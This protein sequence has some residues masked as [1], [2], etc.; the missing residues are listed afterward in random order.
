MPGYFLHDLDQAADIVSEIDHPRL[1]ILFD[2]Y[3]VETQHGRCLTRFLSVARRVGHVQIAS[4]PGRNEPTSGDLD[5]GRLL[6]RIVA[7]GYDG[8]FGC[9]YRETVPAETVLPA[10]RTMPERLD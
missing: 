7:A 2:C 9:E 1:R 5:Y 4:V 10:L 6:P 8:P 3:H